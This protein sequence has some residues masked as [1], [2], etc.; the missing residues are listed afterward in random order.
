MTTTLEE[1]S[2]TFMS[3]EKRGENSPLINV[4]GVKIYMDGVP[5]DAEGGSPMIDHTCSGGQ[6]ISIRRGMKLLMMR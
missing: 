4:D 1:Q 5:N 6:V 3:R 2:K